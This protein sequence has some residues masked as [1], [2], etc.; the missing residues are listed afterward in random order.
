MKLYIVERCYNGDLVSKYYQSKDLAEKEFER[1][2]QQDTE[3]YGADYYLRDLD[4][5]KEQ[6]DYF[7][8]DMLVFDTIREAETE[9]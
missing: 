7:S 5:C 1:I 9:D 2:F 4:T 3:K 8:Q 6:K